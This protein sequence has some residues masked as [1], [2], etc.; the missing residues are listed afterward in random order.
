MLDCSEHVERSNISQTCSHV[1][2]WWTFVTHGASGNRLLIPLLSQK[3]NYKKN[4]SSSTYWTVTFL[5]VLIC[6]SRLPAI[7]GM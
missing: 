2:V 4:G 7:A 5:T 3:C 1:T 6:E